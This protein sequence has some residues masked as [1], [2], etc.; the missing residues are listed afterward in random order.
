MAVASGTAGSVVVG[1]VVVG[2]VKE[3]SLSF[4]REAVEISGMGQASRDF[5]PGIYGYSGSFSTAKDVADA[6][7]VAL[8]SA[9]LGAGTVGLKLYEGTALYTL[10]TVVITGMSPSLSF[11]GASETSYDFQ[12]SGVLT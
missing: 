12:G 8:K 11:D 7:E 1:T 10:G 3:W 9:T 2:R 4:S 5:I 6:G